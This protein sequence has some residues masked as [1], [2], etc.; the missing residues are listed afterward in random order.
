MALTKNKESENEASSDRDL[1]TIEPCNRGLVYLCAI[2][3]AGNK[4]QAWTD[5]IVVDNLSPYD[6]SIN[7]E[8]ENNAEFYNANVPLEIKVNDAPTGD[9]YAGLR[10]VSYQ[11]G[12]NIDE[13]SE[14]II[15]K[16]NTSSTL[17]WEKIQSLFSYGNNNILINADQ[18]ESNNAVVKVT[19]TDNA[20]N[21]STV[22]KQL[23]IDVTKPV[24]EISFDNNNA[25]NQLYYNA[26]RRARIDIT[27]LNFDDSLVD[28]TIYKDGNIDYTQN[29]KLISWTSNEDS[30]HTAYITFD[31][32][33]DYYFEVKCR[34]KADNESELAATEQFT[35]DLT[36][37]IITVEYDNNNPWKENYYNA[38]RTATITVIEHN[39]DEKGCNIT[40]WI[41]N[42]DKHQT[43]IN[44]DEEEYYSYTLSV[45][46]LAGN[47][48]DD[49]GTDDFYIDL[50]LPEIMITGVKDHSANS[51]DISPRVRMTDSNFDGLAVEISLENSRGKRINVT[52]DVLELENGYEYILTNVNEQ[53]DE[54]YTLR[55]NTTD[56]AG[57]KNEAA[58]KFSLNR[59]GSAYDVSQITMLSDKGY[60]RSGDIEDIHITEMNVN[61]VEEFILVMTKNNKAIT[62]TKV[63]KRPTDVEND[64]IYYSVSEKGNDDIGYIYDYTIYKE[65][66]EGEGIYNATFYSKDKAGNEVNNTLDAKN[67]GITF[68]I[69]NTA[70]DI[71][72]DGVGS[73]KFKLDEEK[74]VNIYIRDNFKL[75]E[76]YIEL[77][78]EDGV[79]IE[80]YDYIALSK[81]EGDVV[82]I[83]L[84]SSEK[85]MSLQYYASDAAG[86]EV[87]LLFENEAPKAAGVSMAVL[88]ES[89][90][91][92]S[93]FILIFII[94]AFG[95][96]VLIVASKFKSKS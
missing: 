21:I 45:T 17:S 7:T 48:S 64:V 61:S 73:N 52:S 87:M 71:V 49:F 53:P 15:L 92:T 85:A 24:I 13:L 6:I 8:G 39:F 30:L 69:D 38:Q 10:K 5:G 75:T 41:N 82:T 74:E 63:N 22:T 66:F 62:T 67:A 37:P 2:D 25:S 80:R 54:I 44:F 57:N 46:D 9:N 47:T 29:Q 31:E 14:E 76:A 70:P 20:G 35:I 4:T 11:V 50:T 26:P 12:R 90:T 93:T 95:S 68:I 59:Q 86:N 96:V 42:G 43:T 77:V 55:T 27:E 33:G 58:V 83:T 84:P 36:K 34:D 91:P 72:I 32:D 23:K 1:L 78:D 88:G 65:S 89:D 28:I 19:A 81:N 51:G 18:N 16:E 60:I 79:V 56:M 94:V 3:G 40:G